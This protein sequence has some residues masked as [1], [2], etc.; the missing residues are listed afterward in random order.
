MNRISA[1]VAAMFMSSAIGGQPAHA[2]EPEAVAIAGVRPYERPAGAPAMRASDRD[3]SDERQFRGVV[4][5]YPATLR[6][7][8]NHGG[9]FTPFTEPGMTG[10]Y[11]LRGYHNQRHPQPDV[12]RAGGG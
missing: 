12:V 3:R 6:F 1:A 5:P 2:A 10:R 11:D 7:V 4:A 8:A 9:W